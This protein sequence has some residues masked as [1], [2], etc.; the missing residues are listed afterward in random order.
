[1]D[2]LS[3]LFSIINMLMLH[4][5]VKANFIAQEL[6]VSKRTIYRDI[7]LL[8]TLNVPVY[9]QSGRNGGISIL[10]SYKVSKGL[11]SDEEQQKILHGLNAL[12]VTGIEEDSLLRQKLATI[13]S[14]DEADIY[15]ID[16]SGWGKEREKEKIKEIATATTEKRVVGFSYSDVEDQL[17]ERK[18]LPIRLE[19]KKNAWY[20]NAI[21]LHKKEK[22]LFKLLRMSRIKIMKSFSIEQSE[23]LLSVTDNQMEFIKICLKVKKEKIQ[24]LKEELGEVTLKEEVNEF[25]ILEVTQ[26]TGRWLIHY[27]LSFGS[28]LEVISPKEIRSEIVDEIKKMTAN[29]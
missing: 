9:V 11:V 25:V 16:F 18:V 3:R 27:L 5:R 17:T 12:S 4:D 15:A 8:S 26:P 1:M 7:D 24:K 13:F 14:K 22:R 2:R 23:L 19:F 6:G 10:D 20:L 28:E 21:C 29:Y